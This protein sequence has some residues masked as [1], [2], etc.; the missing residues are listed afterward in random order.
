LF[1]NGEFECYTLEDKDRFLEEGGSKVYGKTA[2]PRGTYNV[3]LT[4]SARF[5]KLLPLL[6]D[7][8]QFRGIRMHSGNKA[9]DSE[10]CILVGMTNTEEDDNWIG[11]SRV[12]LVA[13]IGK[14]QKA[15]DNGE[16]ITL[17]IV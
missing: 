6:E 14:M 10:G 9:E 8:P 3:V 15:I 17:E 2:I 13:L 11:N 5:N 16:E 7:V 4:H 12:A 1:I